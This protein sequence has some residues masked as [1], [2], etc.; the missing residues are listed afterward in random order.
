MFAYFNIF[1]L[2]FV[3][4]VVVVLLEMAG[5]LANPFGRLLD[6]IETEKC[7]FYNPL[8]L[9]DTRYQHLP[10][11]IRVLLEAAIRSC[12]EFEVCCCLLLLLL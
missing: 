2:I 5:K 3:V 10:F 8:K 12:D 4:V 11:S 7:Y 9:S 6:T 1:V